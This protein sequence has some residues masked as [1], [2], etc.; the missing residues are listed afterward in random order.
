M[1]ECTII[2]TSQSYIGNNITIKVEITQQ[3]TN[4]KKLLDTIEIVI[5]NGLNLSNEELKAHALA[6]YEISLQE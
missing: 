2:Y 5:E 4:F 6:V 3:L 1:Y